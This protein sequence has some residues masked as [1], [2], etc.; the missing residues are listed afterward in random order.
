MFARTGGLVILIAF[1]AWNV[2]ET[3]AGSKLDARPVSPVTQSRDGGARTGFTRELHT[4]LIRK[5]VQ[6][7]LEGEWS[8]QVKAVDVTVLEPSEPLRIPSGVVELRVLPS[9]SE[10]GL[11]R[12]LFQ[13][14]IST[15]GRPWKTIEALAD[16]SATVEVVV[17]NRFLKSDELVDV[18]DLTMSKMKV[19]DLKHPF[20]TDPEA[21]AGKSVAR[22]LQAE[23][24]LRASFFKKPLVIKKGDRVMIEAK[25]GGLSIQ[26]SGITKSSGQVGETVMVANL[27]SGRELR[28]KIVAPGLVQVDF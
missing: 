9:A 11:G 8:H 20:V 13:V 14:S 7:Y 16:V 3:E 2:E 15:N 26:T 23:T 22:P 1:L 6:K 24:P 19:Y 4:D 17:P 21:V 12:R 28:A 5:T 27:D 18:Q 25:R 10:E